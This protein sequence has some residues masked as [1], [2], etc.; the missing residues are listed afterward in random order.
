MSSFEKEISGRLTNIETQLAKLDKLEVIK[1]L[2]AEISALKASVDFANNQNTDMRTKNKA[3]E[4]NIKELKTTTSSIQRENKQL[5]NAVLELKCRSM[6]N[7]IVISGLE[8]DVKE[9]STITEQ[10]VKTFLKVSLKMPAADLA[11]MD[12]QRAHRFGKV[13]ID[14]PRPI[15][16]CLSHFKMKF[17]IMGR[18][19]KLKDSPLGLNDQYPKEIM[20]RRRILVPILKEKRKQ[21]LKVK[22]VVDKL[23]FNNEPYKDPTQIDWL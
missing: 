15:V 23:Y 1:N 17:A 11:M 20:D 7:N 6:R 19:R 8:E 3:L 16:A 4:M 13:T 21:K 2:L 14:K 9:D 12:F 22:L 18:G 10:K 5:N